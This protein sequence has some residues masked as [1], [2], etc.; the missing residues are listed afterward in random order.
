MTTHSPLRLLA[1]ALSSAT[2]LTAAI[3]AFAQT[4]DY[5]YSLDSTPQV[6]TG[7]GISY[8][9]G[10]IG[11]GERMAMEAVAKDYN[12]HLTNLNH[13]GAFTDNMNMAIYDAKAKKLAEFNAG[14][15]VYAKLPVGKYV[16]AATNEDGTVRRKNIRVSRPFTNVN[17]VW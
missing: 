5:A 4:S 13:E 9:T 8:I 1:L 10:G 15:M 11:D 14:P 3:P 16:I 17:L 6:Q 2:M 7:E 12:L